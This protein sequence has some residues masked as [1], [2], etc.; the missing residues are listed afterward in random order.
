MMS[1]ISPE[2]HP[3]NDASIFPPDSLRKG[4]MDF[5]V[6]LPGAAQRKR[7][8]GDGGEVAALLFILRAKSQVAC[9]ES[10]TGHFWLPGRRYFDAI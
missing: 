8:V 2:G 7:V 9:Q 4:R 1:I 5:L 10:V 6:V 3:L